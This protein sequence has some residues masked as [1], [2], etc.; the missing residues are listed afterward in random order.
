MN[1]TTARLL[2]V[3]STCSLPNFLLLILLLLGLSLSLA[4]LLLALGLEPTGHADQQ[5]DRQA[6]IDR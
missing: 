6:Q 2:L 4:L 3:S 1:T 5:I